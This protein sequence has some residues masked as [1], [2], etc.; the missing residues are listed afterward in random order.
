MTIKSVFILISDR[1]SGVVKQQIQELIDIMLAEQR[2][3]ILV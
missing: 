3:F 1:Y 2:K